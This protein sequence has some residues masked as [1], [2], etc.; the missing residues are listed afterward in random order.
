MKKILLLIVLMSNLIYS[1]DNIKIKTTNIYLVELPTSGEF[2][3]RSILT[4]WEID[5]INKI[6]SYEIG[7]EQL[8][9]YFEKDELISNDEGEILLRFENNR[10]E[11]Y[12]SS[13]NN[14]VKIIHYS[15][16]E[17]LSSPRS[18]KRLATYSNYEMDNIFEIMGSN[19]N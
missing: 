9:F 13:Y 18:Y 7:N 14:Y 15:K 16:M 2:K 17:P 3:N 10:E 6:I 11:I 12:F 19:I 4:I 1:Q 8:K 5:L